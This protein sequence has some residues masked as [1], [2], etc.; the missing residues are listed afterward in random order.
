MFS[1][2]ERRDMLRI[3]YL[4]NRNP[5][6]ASHRYLYEYPER[7]QPYKTFLKLHENIA[8]CESFVPENI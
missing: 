6:L 5:D 4:Y 8:D 1:D 2:E 3:Y 7:S